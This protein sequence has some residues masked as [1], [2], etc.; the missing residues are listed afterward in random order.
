MYKQTFQVVPVVDSGGLHYEV[1]VLKRTWRGSWRSRFK[2][3]EYGVEN[4]FE[5]MGQVFRDTPAQFQ[6]VGEAVKFIR[7]HYGSLAEIIPWEG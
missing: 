1:K 2:I 4:I 6:S 3:N 5:Q 7:K